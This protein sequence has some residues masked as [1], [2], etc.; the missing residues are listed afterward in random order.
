MESA[1]QNTTTAVPTHVGTD[2]F[3]GLQDAVRALLWL[4]P[5]FDFFIRAEPARVVAAVIGPDG[6]Q[7]DLTGDASIR[8]SEVLKQAT[9]FAARSIP[10]FRLDPPKATV[11]VGY[12]SMAFSQALK[13][14][15]DHEFTVGK[16]GDR[17]WARVRSGGADRPMMLVDLDAGRLTLA[18]ALFEVTSQMK[19]SRLVTTVPEARKAA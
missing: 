4:A 19:A 9:R 1:V 10:P 3:V 15:P 16:Q 11:S 17:I 18:Q 5:D 2:N 13:T 8:V 12:L 14:F 6:N 7:H